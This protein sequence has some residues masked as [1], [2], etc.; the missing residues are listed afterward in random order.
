MK[1]MKVPRQISIKMLLQVGNIGLLIVALVLIF[2]LGFGTATENTLALQAER[3]ASLADAAR[4]HIEFETDPIEEQ[5]NWIAEGVASGELSLERPVELGNILSGTSA[6]T[7]TLDFM[8]LVS[9]EGMG[10]GFDISEAELPETI[11]WR[12]DPDVIEVMEQSRTWLAGQWLPPYWIPEMDGGSVIYVTP[13]KFKDQ[14]AGMLVQA[15]NVQG[16]SAR[17]S[18]LGD[19]EIYVPY[20]LYDD[21]QVIAHKSL[22]DMEIVGREGAPLPSVSEIGDP[23]LNLRHSRKPV[24][25]QL[26][27]LRGDFDIGRSVIDGIGYAYLETK[28]NGFADKPL[29]VGFYFDQELEIEA[30]EELAESGFIA[31]VIFILAVIVVFYISRKTANPIIELAEA[32][33]RVSNNNLSDFK[34]LRHSH[35][36]EIDEAF[37]AFNGMIEGLRERSHI[38]ELFGRMVP[39]KVA[40]KLINDPEGLAPQSTTAT[41]LFCDIEKFTAISEKIKPQEIVELLNA[42]F[43]DMVE[44]I[45]RHGGIITQFQ[46]DAILAVFNVP[47]ADDDH[48]AEA[49]QAAREMQAKLAE[50]SYA[51]VQLKNR[52]GINT[53][54]LVAGN[55]GAEKRMNY[56][57]H[58][59]AVNTAARLEQLNKEYG[60]RILISE[61]THQ[62]AGDGGLAFVDEASLRG[63]DDRVRVYTVAT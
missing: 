6:G 10:I 37:N 39:E 40:E 48:A 60:T 16:V 8:A 24:A 62:A 18:S 1:S 57:V 41:V 36:K 32:S 46:G 19:G 42:Y 25:M 9:P 56:T 14:Y 61:E 53:G 29:I 34:P 21:D 50:S 49:I 43:S 54:H 45:E 58:G 22:A 63:K 30:L 13:L 35:L 20:I 59:D 55:V 28:V 17:L 44:I 27:R 2:I 12:D 26:E 5:A 4:L 33:R 11:D 15:K 51:G 23:V 31:V 38:R 3:A 7:P 52:I 47:V